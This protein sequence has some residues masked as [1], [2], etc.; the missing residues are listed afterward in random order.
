MNVKKKKFYF[1]FTWAELGNTYFVLKV[2]VCL[3]Q[4]AP[5]QPPKSSK[6]MDS[7]K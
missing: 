1:H 5:Y 7:S 4:L 2:T 3:I 6:I